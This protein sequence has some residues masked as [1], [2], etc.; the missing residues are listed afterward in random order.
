M[1]R[2]ISIP[3]FF[4]FLF[5]QLDVVSGNSLQNSHFAFNHL[6]DLVT[7]VSL[8]YNFLLALRVLCYRR[9]SRKLRGEL[10]RRLLE[11]DIEGLK[12]VYR[13]DMFPFVP[14]NSLDC[15]LDKTGRNMLRSRICCK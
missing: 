2:P 10:L 9:A 13:G 6:Q 8:D 5:H 4:L 1:K 14:F 15:Y 11:I 7:D 3:T 12:T